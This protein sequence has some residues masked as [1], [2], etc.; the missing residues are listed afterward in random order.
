M[1]T[2]NE[3]FGSPFGGLLDDAEVIHRYTRADLVRDGFLVEVPE[4]I[5]K[6]CG[7]RV[8]VGILREVWEDAV[9]WSEADSER[10][11]HQDESGRLFDVLFMAAHAARRAPGNTDTVLFKVARIPRD[12]KA[13]QPELVE[14]RSIIGP[15]DDPRPVITILEIDQD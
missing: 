3:N 5:A 15:G 1:Q 11:T 6:E 12:G 13:T 4:A 7:F 2:K 14:F 8:P 9:A 10:Q